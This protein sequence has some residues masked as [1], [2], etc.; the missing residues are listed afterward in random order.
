MDS[1]IGEME[2]G[3]RLKIFSS[4]QRKPFFAHLR[5]AEQIHFARMFRELGKCTVTSIHPSG[6]GGARSKHD[7]VMYLDD[8][9]RLQR[10]LARLHRKILISGRIS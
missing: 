5:K 10:R 2:S 3:L 6:V 1:S 8:A 4:A 7:V 9:F